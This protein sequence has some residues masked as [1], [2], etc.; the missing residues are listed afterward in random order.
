MGILFL[1]KDRAWRKKRNIIAHISE[2]SV[3]NRCFGVTALYSMLYC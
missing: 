1:V 2:Q 3:I